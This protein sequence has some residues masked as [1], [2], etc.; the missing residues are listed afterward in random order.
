MGESIKELEKT[1]H[2]EK[3]SNSFSPKPIQFFLKSNVV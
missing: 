1:H 3:I 2:Y